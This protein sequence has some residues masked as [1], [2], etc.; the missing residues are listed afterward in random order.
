MFLEHQ[1]EVTVY[2]LMVLFK[3]KSSLASNWSASSDSCFLLLLQG[4]LI[5]LVES[6][7]LIF[8]HRR[9]FPHPRSSL[10]S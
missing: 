3:V 5:F 7:V 10:A 6:D 2:M 1:P 9:A 4:L 8:I